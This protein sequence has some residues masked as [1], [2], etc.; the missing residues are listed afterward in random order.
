MN[1]AFSRFN[2]TLLNSYI[3]L[4][5][6]FL[7]DPSGGRGSGLSDEQLDMIS[8]VAKRLPPDSGVAIAGGVSGKNVVEFCRRISQSVGSRFSIDAQGRLRGGK[9]EGRRIGD[10]LNPDK[11]H[12]YVSNAATA[13]LQIA[14]DITTEE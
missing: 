6:Q 10:Q 2:R 3:D 7:F 11:V 8:S 5:N 4:V 1:Q 12:L 13:L 14:I 9:F